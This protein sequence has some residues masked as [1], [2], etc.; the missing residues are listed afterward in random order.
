MTL[1][2]MSSV[3]AEV[4]RRRRAIEKPLPLFSK[5]SDSPLAAASTTQRQHARN[6]AA[7]FIITSSTAPAR[8]S[9][10]VPAPAATM[11]TP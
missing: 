6:D 9:M 2:R 11:Q 7:T 8:R 10:R 4:E 3:T 1:A 5:D